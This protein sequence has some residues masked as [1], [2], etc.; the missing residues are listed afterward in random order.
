MTLLLYRAL[1][2][3]LPRHVRERDG[4]EMTRAL[5]DQIAG[6]RAPWAVRWRA[7]IRFPLVLALE[8]RDVLFAGRVP[9]PPVSSRGSRMDSVVR[10]IRQGARALAR[11]PAFSISV[12]LLLGM[13]VGS[14][15]AIFAVVDHV[16]LRPLPYPDADRLVVIEGSHSIPA[17]RDMQTMQ[18]VEAWAAASI[19]NARMTGRGD[20]VR[21]RQAVVTDGFFPMFG[22]RA[23]IGRLLQPADSQFASTV[24]LSYGTWVRMFGS[25]ATVIGSTIRIDDS[26]VTVV[27]VLDASFPVPERIVGATVDVW[28]P[29]DPGADYATKRDYWMFNVAGR[30]GV[31]ATTAQAQQEADRVANERAQAFPGR[32]TEDGRVLELPVHTLRDATIGN[33]DQPLRAL[34]GAVSLLLL[35]ACANVTHLFLARGVGRIR[36][37][38][39]RRALGARTRSLLAQLLIESGMLGAAGAILGASIAYAGVRV[40][41][42]LAP[43]GLPRASTI[44]VDARVLLFAAGVGL[45]TAIV[46]GLLPALRLARSGSGQPLRDS[47]RTLTES[48]AAHRLRSALVIGEVAVS[49]VLVANA[50]WLLRSF[51][52]MSQADLGFRTSGVVEIPLSIATPTRASGDSQGAPAAA[53]HRRME[54]IRES[55]AQTRG[56]QRAT[57]GL[58][59]PLEWVGGGKCCWSAR[60]NFAGKELPRLSV[61]HPVSDDYF[62][63]FAIRLVAGEAWTRGTATRAPYPAVIN[64]ALAK[65]FFGA[66]NAAVGATFVLDQ[67]DYRVTG[68]ARNT[69]HY[70]ADQPYETALYIPARSLPFAPD[71]VTMAVLSDRTDAALGRDLRAAVWRAE[72]NLPVPTINAITELARRDSAYRRFDALLF[73]TFSVVALLLVAGGLAGTLLYMVSLQRRSLGIRLALGATP[74][75]LERAVLTRGVSLAASGAIIGTIGAWFAGRLIESRLYGV[76]ARDALTLGLAVSVLM[77]IALLS[78]WI[79]ARRAAVTDPIESLRA[80]Y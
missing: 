78:S 41:L 27:G 56:V 70:G 28:R 34:L 71:N 8:W 10:M 61:T 74:R 63:V 22:A 54:A 17:L 32:Y 48:L 64:E 6:A 4:E 14:V 44:A 7:L 36:E 46:F 67:T 77:L 16:L 79:P 1:I 42:A 59:M 2:R 12:V 24:V 76:Q 33:V 37:M 57:F 18:A 80:E 65:Q 55:L 13:G 25:D 73:G 20:P 23:A 35:V 31:A 69:R 38:A 43:G 50:G 45:L 47:R 40:F 62:D 39:V 58:S 49:L 21:L 72:P 26:P 30:L 19:D 68:V 3:L 29:I 75:G 15:S 66:A 11:T 5:A 9:A 53:W 60:P 52:R 51:I